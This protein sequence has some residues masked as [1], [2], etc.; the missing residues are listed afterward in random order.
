[1]KYWLI[2]AILA[3]VLSI[4]GIGESQ[5]K[6]QF[7]DI[8][9]Q[10]AIDIEFSNCG[11]VIFSITGYGESKQIRYYVYEVSTTVF[12]VVEFAPKSD[13]AIAIYILEPS[14]TVLKFVPSEFNKKLPGPCKTVEALNLKNERNKF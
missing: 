14:K 2:A 11:D 5:T 7:P 6:S 13:Q 12:A 1:M 10:E 8:R 3:F 4:G 9:E